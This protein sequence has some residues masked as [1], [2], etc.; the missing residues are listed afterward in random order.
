MKISDVVRRSQR[1]F[2]LS[3][4]MGALCTLVLSSMMTVILILLTFADNIVPM[5]VGYIEE[6]HPQMLDIQVE[7]AYYGNKDILEY[8]GLSNIRVEAHPVYYDVVVEHSGVPID[9]VERC[10]ATPFL[11]DDECREE[12][13][14]GRMYAAAD[15]EGDKPYVW[16]GENVANEYGLAVGDGIRVGEDDED[17][18]RYEV[19]GVF[20]EESMYSDEILLS[21]VPLYEKTE[22]HYLFFDHSVYADLEDLSQYTRINKELEEIL[23]MSLSS[24]LESVYVMT[25]YIWMVLVALGGFVLVVGMS[26]VYNLFN[27][28]V[29][30]R[31]KFILLQ[32]ML[33]C[34]T[35]NI[36]CGYMLIFA[37]LIVLSSVL[38]AILTVVATL[39]FNG[40]V[41]ALFAGC[42]ISLSPLPVFVAVTLA[43][44]LVFMGL[45]MLRL[46]REVHSVNIMEVAGVIE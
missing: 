27:M 42:S 41:D 43:S 18:G 38:S 35:G 46:Y 17:L 30:K 20:S 8:Y 28:Y 9:V 3:G 21:F 39:Y 19:M 24:P 32:K 15:N 22:E 11:F 31:K 34:R 7:G 25:D 29:S 26:S 2:R 6:N 10:R 12:L 33:G 14:Q 40:V 16:I 1:E 13:I 45:S 37:F 36:V 4:H 44:C 23:F 5:Y